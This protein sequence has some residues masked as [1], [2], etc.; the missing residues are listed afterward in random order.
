MTIGEFIVLIGDSIF[1]MVVTTSSSK[2]CDAESVAT[3]IG[4]EGIR[5][6]KFN[7]LCKELVLTS[8]TGARFVVGSG[9]NIASFFNPCEVAVMRL[10]ALSFAS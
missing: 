10:I 5:E 9:C 4:E 7:P 6:S 1:E 2:E 3:M 8:E